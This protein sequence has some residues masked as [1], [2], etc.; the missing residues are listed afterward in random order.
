MSFDLRVLRDKTALLTEL[1]REWRRC[2]EWGTLSAAEWR[3]L[4]RRVSD[5]R[6]ALCKELQRQ[7]ECKWAMVRKGEVR[8][9]GDSRTRGIVGL[10]VGIAFTIR[11]CFPRRF[12]SGLLADLE[13]VSKDLE[14][15]VTKLAP[16]R[17]KKGTPG[18]PADYD[19]EVQKFA[20]RLR[21]RNPK[22]P[23]K[24]IRQRCRVEHPQAKLPPLT[25]G[26]F[27][28]WVKRYPPKKG[29]N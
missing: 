9:E 12:P 26:L 20:A 13:Q 28:S 19:P 2:W 8:I 11:V 17:V 23:Y 6:R 1:C 14:E 21:N 15:A 18:R 5:A 7:L 24:E 22:M 16:P 4:L 29:R 3:T 27:R 10:L 25:D